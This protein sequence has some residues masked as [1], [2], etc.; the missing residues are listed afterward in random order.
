[1]AEI[2]TLYQGKIAEREIFLK[3]KIDEARKNRD[4]DAFEELR[5]QLASERKSLEEECE[6]EK[7]RVRK[8]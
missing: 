1:M 5:P 2:D 6:E 8:S 4:R 7:D 3:Q